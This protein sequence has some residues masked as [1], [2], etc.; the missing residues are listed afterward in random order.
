MLGGKTWHLDRGSM[1]GLAVGDPVV[2]DITE[3]EY[4]FSKPGVGRVAALSVKATKMDAPHCTPDGRYWVNFRN[5]AAKINVDF[6]R[7]E[8]H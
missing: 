5:D 8:D 7:W 3:S 4:A 1:P 6:S 2:I